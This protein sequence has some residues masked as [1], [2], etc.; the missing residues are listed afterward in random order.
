MERDVLVP[1]QNKPARPDVEI[2]I[3]FVRA[4]V[5]DL[6]ASRRFF[7][8]TLGCEPVSRG[9]HGPEHEEAWGLP[10][11][12]PKVLTVA[13]GDRFLELVEYDGIGRDWPDGYRISDEGILNLAFGS[14]EP[15][16]YRVTRERVATGGYTL[17]RE[18]TI[19]PEQALNYVTDDQGFNIELLY[20]GPAM[21]LDFGFVPVEKEAL[22]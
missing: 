18:L 14:V 15:E 12:Q 16:P 11:A 2:A 10:D 21:H 6:A 5:P 17:H 22:G 19:P 7:V 20:S 8:D 13:S 1:G 9:L 3:R 4:T